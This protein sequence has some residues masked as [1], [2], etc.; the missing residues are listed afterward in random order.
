[1]KLR[2][3]EVSRKLALIDYLKRR[4]SASLHNLV[5]EPIRPSNPPL[6]ANFIFKVNI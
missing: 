1:M 6:G 3:K 4:I 5:R 2:T